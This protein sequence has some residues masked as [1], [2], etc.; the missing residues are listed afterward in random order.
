MLGRLFALAE[1]LQEKPISL[2][3]WLGGLLSLIAVRNVLES[4]SGGIPL[5]ELGTHFLHYP[6]ALIVALLALVLLLSAFSRMPVV[7]PTRL[8][9]YPWTLILLPPLLDLAIPGSETKII[10]Y[11]PATQEPGWVLLSFFNPWARGR[12]ITPG[13]RIEYFLGCMLAGAYI[14]HFGRSWLRAL[15]GFVCIYLVAVALAMKPGLYLWLFRTMGMEAGSRKL[16]IA[17]GSVIRHVSNRYSYSLALLDVFNLLVLLAVWLRAHSRRLWSACWKELRL[18]EPLAAAVGIWAGARAFYHQNTLRQVFTH[19]LDVLAAAALVL[20]ALLLTM[21]ARHLRSQELRG[22]ASVEILLGFAAALSV[23]YAA[24]T[25]ATMLFG[26]LILMEHGP[27]QARRTPAVG[28]VARGAALVASSL[29]GLS[30]LHRMDVPHLVSPAAMGMTLLLA[31]LSY[32]STRWPALR[33]FLVI[34]ALTVFFWSTSSPLLFPRSASP[35]SPS[36]RAM[37]LGYRAQAFERDHEFDHAIVDYERAIALGRDEPDILYSLA[38]L[39]AQRGDTEEALRLYD[40]LLGLEPDHA[41]ALYQKG[42]LLAL[43]GTS[44]D[45]VYRLVLAIDPDLLEARRSLGTLLLEREAYEEALRHFEWLSDRDPRSSWAHNGAALSLEG[46]GRFEDAEREHRAAVRLN[47]GDFVLRMNLA[48]LLAKRGKLAEARTEA[49]K[50]LSRTAPDV[51]ALVEFAGLVENLGDTERALELYRAAVA[52][53][54]DDFSLLLRA[55]IAHDRNGRREQGRAFFR[56]ASRANPDSPQ[57][58]HNLGVSYLAEG[59]LEEAHEAFSQAAGLAPHSPRHW[60]HL[61]VVAARTGR[62]DEAVELLHKAVDL[63]GPE[64]AEMA[65]NEHALRRLPFDGQSETPNHKT[66]IPEE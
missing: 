48:K 6:F 46:L 34:A 5:P 22:L 63:G 61:A 25:I 24:F 54:P 42:H 50:I 14:Y 33:S 41:R 64:Y 51:Q 43:G 3:A 38:F 1:R 17:H 20:T 47:P 52:A 60:Y 65:R 13:V 58:P 2:G 30:L 37:A 53:A 39:K 28:A 36:P 9:L 21:G 27:F 23:H 44:P 18:H 7:K 66:Q 12:I 31:S 59:R 40:Q 56:R 29:L 8:I 4:F 26:L 15:L 45:S 10:G 62:Y 19:P 11:V 35:Y 49:R 16:F 32:A 57:P 55:G